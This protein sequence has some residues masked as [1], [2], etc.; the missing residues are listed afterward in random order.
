[1]NN[2]LI[3]LANYL[4]E[5]GFKREADEVDTLIRKDGI[6]M[7]VPFLL[8][9]GLLILGEIIA[10]IGIVATVAWVIYEL[11]KRY[12]PESAGAS[13]VEDLREALL[14]AKEAPESEYPESENRVPSKQSVDD[15]IKKILDNLPPPDIAL[16]DDGGDEPGRRRVMLTAILVQPLGG[17]RHEGFQYWFLPGHDFEP[18]YDGVERELM[19]RWDGDFLRWSRGFLGSLTIGD[20]CQFKFDTDDTNYIIKNISGK[21]A[22]SMSRHNFE[23]PFE[24]RML[25]ATFYIG[26]ADTISGSC[27][28]QGLRWATYDE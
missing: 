10:I 28:G 19:A 2:K 25:P 13:A 3:N 5:S 9:E 24:G 27:S 8:A 20:Y 15:T 21:D 18:K 14:R 22:M 1:M 11:V 7:A 17:E 4:D 23:F 16:P 12:W 26:N 6:A